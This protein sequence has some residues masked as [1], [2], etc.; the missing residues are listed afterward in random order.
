MCGCLFLRGLG[1][2]R[3]RSNLMVHRVRV[4]VCSL[5]VVC[6]T[7]EAG[8]ARTSWWCRTARGRRCTRSS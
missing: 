2:L 8:I 6:R 7:R 4:V 1:M 5:A 3:G